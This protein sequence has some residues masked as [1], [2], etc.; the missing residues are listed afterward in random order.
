MAATTQAPH[1]DRRASSGRVIFWVSWP[2]LSALTAAW[3]SVT[4]HFREKAGPELL[5]LGLLSAGLLL[6]ATG[7]WTGLL[8]PVFYYD[9]IRTARRGQL[10]AHRFLFVFFLASALFLVYVSYVPGWDWWSFAPTLQVPRR[11]L[12]QFS[13]S[14]V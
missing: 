9:V 4:Y 1:R 7:S 3:L 14:F 12:P 8:S 2:F 11:E 5:L 10:Q 6:V 13:W